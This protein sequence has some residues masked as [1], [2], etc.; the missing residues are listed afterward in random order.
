MHLG[1]F[2]VKI[3]PHVNDQARSRGVSNKLINTLLARLKKIRRSIR[4]FEPHQQFQLLDTETGVALGMMRSN[5]DP[6]RLLF[7]TVFVHDER[8]G[9]DPVVRIR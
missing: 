6:D 7:N 2:D 8:P 1:G 5:E 9:R 3:S 4:E